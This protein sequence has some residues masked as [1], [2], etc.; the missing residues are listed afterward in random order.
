[1]PAVT[2][3]KPV[4]H[5]RENLAGWWS[6]STGSGEEL[7]QYTSEF[8]ARASGRLNAVRLR[9]DLVIHQPYDRQIREEFDERTGGM[10]SATRGEADETR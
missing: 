6:V 9:A 2:S 8:Q 1:M 4:V 3:H 5:V 7:A 10:R